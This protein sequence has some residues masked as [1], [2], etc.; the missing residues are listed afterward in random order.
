MAWQG[1]RACGDPRRSRIS[2]GCNNGSKAQQDPQD[3]LRRQ[4]SE[5]STQHSDLA[6]R[7]SSRESSHEW[8]KSSPIEYDDDDSDEIDGEDNDNSYDVHER[9]PAHRVR[10]L[11]TMKTPVVVSILPLPGWPSARLEYFSEVQQDLQLV[12]H[13]A[14]S[15]VVKEIQCVTL[16]SHRSGGTASKQVKKTEKQRGSNFG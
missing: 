13:D 6:S 11:E 14:E 3:E 4:L 1:S 10:L 5:L 16:E 15:C 9:P 7:A 12:M 8:R 2:S